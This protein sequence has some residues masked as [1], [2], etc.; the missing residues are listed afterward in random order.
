MRHR[1][2]NPKLSKATDQ[3]IAMLASLARS[4]FQ[5]GKIKTTETRAKEARRLA[6]KIITLCKKNDLS[7]RR[8]VFSYLRDRN[9]VGRIFKEF[10]QRFEGR[11]GGFTRVI[12]AGLR[13]G[14][15]APLAVLELV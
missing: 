11:A 9:L 1:K 14:D 2:G 15:A 7:S 8:R 12:K 4:L 5:Y 13:V 10:P 6:E 3:R